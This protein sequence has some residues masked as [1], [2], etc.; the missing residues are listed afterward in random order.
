MKKI[1]LLLFCLLFP[2]ML[3]G[4][5]NL[6]DTVKVRVDGLV[7][8]LIASLDSTEK[9]SPAIHH[10]AI[11]VKLMKQGK[12]VGKSIFPLS[13]RCPVEEDNKG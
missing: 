6:K 3:N 11:C 4:K 5:G 8:E 7:Y 12:V 9:E 2:V 1:Q 13:G 10:P